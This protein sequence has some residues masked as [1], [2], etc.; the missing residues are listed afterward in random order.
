MCIVYLYS[1]YRDLDLRAYM[2]EPEPKARSMIMR[3][4]QAARDKCQFQRS[5][6]YVMC[7][8]ISIQFHSQP[9]NQ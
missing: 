7:Y 1:V 3:A 5:V 2:Y 8:Q 9:L 4:R 6:V